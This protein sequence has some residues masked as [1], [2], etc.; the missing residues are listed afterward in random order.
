MEEPDSRVVC[1]N[2]QGYRVHGRYLNGVTTHGVGLPFDEWRVEGWV[3]GCVVLSAV[4]DGHLVPMQV[5]AWPE[6]RD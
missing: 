6:L 4:D 2:T 3:T 1:D 5:T